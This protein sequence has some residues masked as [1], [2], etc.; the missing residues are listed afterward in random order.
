MERR[1]PKIFKALSASVD[2]L[3]L[4]QALAPRK[5]ERGSGEERRDSTN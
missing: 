3:L 1:R 5:I 2:A 4:F